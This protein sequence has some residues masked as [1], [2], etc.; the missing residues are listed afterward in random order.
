MPKKVSDL[1]KKEILNLFLQGTDLKE[2]SRKYSFSLA[3]IVRQLKKILGAEE[4][5]LLKDKNNNL[6]KNQNKF[7][8]GNNSYKK[9]DLSD[10]FVEVIPIFEGIDL[11]KQNEYASELLEEAHLPEVVYMI[12]DK[13]IELTPKMLSEYSEWSFMPKDDLKRMTLEI[14]DDHKYAKKI[15]TKNQKLIKVPNSKVFLIASNFLKAKGISRIIFN[16][17]L[18]AF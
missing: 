17:S 2:I 11:D 8:E 4:Y 6:S 12:V 15:C 10:E 3:T 5:S 13:N 16:N 7:V 9:T 1:E 14:F 18:L